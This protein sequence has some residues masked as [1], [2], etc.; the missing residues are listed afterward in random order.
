LLAGE[1]SDVY[2]AQKR[3]CELSVLKAAKNFL[4]CF[5]HYVSKLVKLN[6]I[7]YQSLLD[8]SGGIWGQIITLCIFTLARTFT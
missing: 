8:I 2:L 6:W 7:A 3:R 4:G 5:L 1:K